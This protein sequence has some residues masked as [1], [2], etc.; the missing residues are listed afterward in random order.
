[1][2][3][4]AGIFSYAQDAA[5]AADR[6]AETDLII[7]SP[8]ENTETSASD[9]VEMP[10]V[11]VGDFLRVIIVLSVVI[12]LIYFFVWLLKKFT[13]IKTESGDAIRIYSTRS[14]KGDTALHLVETGKR[15]FLIGSSGN[16]INLISEIDDR[17]SMDEIRLNAS[18]E[19]VGNRGGFSRFFREKFGSAI[20][21]GEESGSLEQGPGSADSDPASFMRKQRERLKKL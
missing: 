9:A 14:L 7:S 10:G 6:P 4:C 20:S 1:M 17:E 2:L 21:A 5:G 12:A 11:G 8:P 15:I 3:L 19:S 13:G 18:V 16:S